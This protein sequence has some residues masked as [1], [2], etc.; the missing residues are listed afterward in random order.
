MAKNS[1]RTVNTWCGKTRQHEGATLSAQCAGNLKESCI[2]Y[3]IGPR[4]GP[5]G[6]T[7]QLGFIFNLSTVEIDRN[8]L[9]SIDDRDNLLPFVGQC[10]GR[11]SGADLT[12]IGRLARVVI[13]AWLPLLSSVIR[14]I[15]RNR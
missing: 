10:Q 7:E 15:L 5:K 9:Y 4:V 3:I 13:P 8:A 12:P 1:V 11:P 2:D 14:S 6:M